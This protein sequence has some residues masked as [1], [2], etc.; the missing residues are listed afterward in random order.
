MIFSETPLS[1]SYIVEPERIEDERGFFACTWNFDEFRSR[2]LESGLVE[3]DIAWNARRGTLRGMHFQVPP[4]DNAKLVR[5][6]MG[7][8]FDVIIDLRPDSTSRNG[9]FGMELSGQ[10]RRML[11][12]PG[13]FAHGYITLTDGAEVTYQ[14]SGAHH[15]EAARGVRWNDPALGIKWPQAPTCILPRDAS[16]PLLADIGIG[17]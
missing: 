5:C 7:A 12:V 13:G 3:C 4:F 9:W 16:Y 1:G 14:I 8:I 15:P 6:T 17:A 11:Y 10:N 2:G